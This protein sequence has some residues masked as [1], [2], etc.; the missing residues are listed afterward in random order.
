[1]GFLNRC[2]EAGQNLEAVGSD[3]DHYHAAVPGFAAARNQA[4]LFQSVK[5]ARDVRIAGNHAGSNF[6]AR[7]ALWSSAQ[8]AQHVVLRRRQILGLENQNQAAGEHVGGA[9]QIQKSGLLRTLGTTSFVAGPN[10]F[11]HALIIVVITNTVKTSF[12]NDILESRVRRMLKPL[13]RKNHLQ[14]TT[15][16]PGAKNICRNANILIKS[17]S[18]RPPRAFA[19]TA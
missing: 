3:P 13:G 17:S 10:W 15:A 18:P 14:F 16:L 2:V 11:R 12:S 7:K 6:A 9:R 1:M 19:R 5:Q 4:A 8:D